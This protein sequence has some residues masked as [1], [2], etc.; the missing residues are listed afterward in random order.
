MTCDHVD[1]N[2]HRCGDDTEFERSFFHPNHDEYVGEPESPFPLEL[3]DKHK[4]SKI[5]WKMIQKN[6]EILTHTYG[7][8]HSIRTGKESI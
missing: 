4:K 7:T 1:K 8:I 2:E 5:T 3:C 6:N